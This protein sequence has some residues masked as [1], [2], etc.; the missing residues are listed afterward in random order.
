MA[1]WQ[2]GR[3]KVGRRNADDPKV[4]M[5]LVEVTDDPWLGLEV[6]GVAVGVWV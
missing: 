1:V 3:L 2:R 5:L 6:L 4:R